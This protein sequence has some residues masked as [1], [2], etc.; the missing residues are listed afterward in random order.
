[1]MIDRAIEWCFAH[2]KV[3]FGVT[4]LVIV[5]G[6]YAWTQLSIT[7]Y[8]ELADVNVE[9]TTAVPGLA[10]QEIE[11]EITTPLERALA[12]VPGLTAMR[13]SSTFGLSL[14][15]LVF[16]GSHDQYWERQRVLFAL[17]QVPLPPG[18]TPGL[19]PVSGPSGEIYRYT[20]QSDTKN[21]MELSEIQHW[22]VIPALQAIPGV[23][24]VDN[25]G[26]FTKE[27]QLE[28]DPSALLR[29]HVSATQV[30]QAIQNN[31]SN[32]IGGRIVRGEQSY[33]VRAVG[34]VHSLADLGDV[35]V[36]EAH[37]VPVSIRDLGTLLYGHQI[38]QGVLGVN[39]DPDA[40]EGIVDRLD[41]ADTLTVLQAVHAK[42]A[43]LNARLVPD[44][45]RIVPYYDRDYLVRSTIRN[46][47][48]IVLEG[49]ALVCVVLFLFV[50]D[51]RPAL[52][53]AV[54][55]PLALMTVFILMRVTRM[56]MNRF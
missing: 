54:T 6:A 38:R 21:L 16:D 31:T 15:T 23:A 9:V 20:L 56:P 29:Y 32:A 7:A 17:S 22:T 1:M 53:V 51:V 36:T 5:L 24:N 55:I 2:R 10:A 25:F 27:F 52:V 45:V 28:L 26:G 4:A 33:V 30:V 44:G 49:V 8:P 18:V 19:N 47:F 3:F 14:V 13:S 39:G 12:G 48:K 42:V 50:G 34:M 37:G 43:E 46:V 11:Q 35:A 41:G 40:V